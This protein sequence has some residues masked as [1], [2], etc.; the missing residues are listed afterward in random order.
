MAGC[1]PRGDGCRA[2]RDRFVPACP[3]WICSR[4]GC[5]RKLV[6]RRVRSAT[7]AQL[8]YNDAAGF[9]TCERRSPNMSRRRAA[10][11]SARIRSSSSP[12]P[13][14]RSTSCVI[15]CLDSGDKA[16]LEE[17]GYPGARSALVGAGARIVPV[18]VDEQGLD[19]DAG[20]RRAP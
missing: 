7:I 9:P 1:H 13:S 6:N 18:R 3:A 8:D 16:W 11:A 14:V 17:P 5:G 4:C 2:H 20:I 12:A 19:V 10:H 15:C